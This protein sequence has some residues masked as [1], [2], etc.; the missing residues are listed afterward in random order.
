MP[1]PGSTS[2][3][4]TLLWNISWSLC[5][6]TRLVLL[7]TGCS[8]L[9]ML[10]LVLV[11]LGFGSHRGWKFGFDT[12]LLSCFAHGAQ[13][14]SVSPMLGLNILS[15]VCPSLCFS[16]IAVGC[17][18]LGLL[19]LQSEQELHWPGWSL[20]A[21]SCTWIRPTITHVRV[22][23]YTLIWRCEVLFT[24]CRLT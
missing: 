7:Y 9:S 2:N 12:F 11:L 6:V 19:F 14:H 13:I 21:I 8:Q 10:H 23:F 4:T 17:V 22:P 3:A 18:Y 1:C 5:T 16:F 24:T 15:S 20:D